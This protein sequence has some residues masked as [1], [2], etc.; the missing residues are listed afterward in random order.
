MMESFIPPALPLPIP[1]NQGHGHIAVQ[2]E[3]SFEPTQAKCPLMNQTQTAREVTQTS[4]QIQPMSHHLQQQLCPNYRLFAR[5]YTDLSA[6]KCWQ[7]KKRKKWTIFCGFLGK[8]FIPD[9]T[10]QKPHYLQV[11][12]WSTEATVKQNKQKASKCINFW[13]SIFFSC[14]FCLVGFCLVLFKWAR[15][16]DVAEVKVNQTRKQKSNIVFMDQ[17]TCI[18][19]SKRYIFTIPFLYHIYNTSLLPNRLFSSPPTLSFCS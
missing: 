3:Q 6:A 5:T 18:S 10:I 2:R 13:K 14:Y 1:Q 12:I 9:Y 19:F 4:A 15:N 7:K 16:R 17:G 11:L 8:L